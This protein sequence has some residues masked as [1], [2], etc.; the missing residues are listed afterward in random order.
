[1][2]DLRADLMKKRVK[3]EELIKSRSK[4]YCSTVQSSKDD[5]TR[6]TEIEELE[7]EIRELEEKLN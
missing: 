4:A 3:L 7:D 5:V 1:M 6:E 2:D